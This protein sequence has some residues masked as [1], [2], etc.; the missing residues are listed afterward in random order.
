MLDATA[1][2]V[3]AFWNAMRD[4]PGLS[5]NLTDLVFVNWTRLDPQAALAAVAGSGNEATAWWTWSCNDPEAALAT[6][7]ASNQDRINNVAWGIGEFHPDWLMRNFDRI[8]ESARGEALSGLEK[9]DDA[10][11][12]LAVLEFL[13]RHGRGFNDRLF[14]T[15]VHRDPWAAYEWYQQHGKPL[16]RLF[17]SSFSYHGQIGDT[18]PAVILA[19]TLAESRPDVLGRIADQAP[20]GPFKRAMEATLFNRLIRTD[21]DAAMRQAIATKAPL[22]ATQRLSTLG[23]VEISRDTEKA[24][25]IA[26]YLLKQGAAVLHDKTEV[27]TDTGTNGGWGTNMEV[28][29][30]VNA[31]MDIDPARA[32]QL[33]PAPKDDL[34]DDGGAYV[35]MLA[36][37]AD[38]DVDGYLQWMDAQTDP[39]VKSQTTRP[40]IFALMNAERYSEAMEV[41]TAPGSG[42]GGVSS[43]LMR[44][45]EVDPAAARRWLE[46]AKLPAS[47]RAQCESLLQRSE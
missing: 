13:R 28:E 35:Q 45:S 22:I 12:P 7:I 17:D 34:A 43:M 32:V 16:S 44:W 4:R 24:F 15:L 38:R 30:F 40:L 42:A 8:P 21:P 20:Q 18:D 36:K 26:G 14:A 23:V 19:R 25:E 39:A 6:A 41:A 5:K 3:A 9:R 1:Q 31:L 29:R 47:E 46:Q 11:D 10:S 37:W 33:I 2:E 27:R